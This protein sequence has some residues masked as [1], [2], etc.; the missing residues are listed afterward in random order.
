MVLKNC[1]NFKN[2][3]NSLGNADGLGLIREKEL[4]KVATYLQI[5]NLK[6]IN[7]DELKDGMQT[8]WDITLIKE[9]LSK[10]IIENKIDIV[11]T[12]DKFGVSSHLNHIS[13]R[14]A[15]DEK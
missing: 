3:K 9:I 14:N 11:I 13:I 10:Y 12:F 4:K 8:K 15:L 1:K 6:I 5:R 7:N 2:K